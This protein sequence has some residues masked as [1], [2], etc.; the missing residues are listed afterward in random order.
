MRRSAGALLMVLCGCLARNPAFDAASDAGATPVTTTGSGVAPTSSET[1]ATSGTT[2]DAT[3]FDPVATGEPSTGE[4]TTSTTTTATSATTDAEE[5][6]PDGCLATE[7]VQL[8]AV[9]LDTAV[10]PPSMPVPCPWN[11]GQVDPEHDCGEFNFGLA[12]SH[13]LVHGN[14][15]KNAALLRFPLAMITGSLESSGHALGDL[16]GFRLVV[17]FEEYVAA[18]QQTYVFRVDLLH[19]KDVDF[20][21]GDKVSGVAGFGDSSFAC[22]RNEGGQCVPWNAPGGPLAASAKMGVMRL[23]PDGVDLDET[24]DAYRIQVRSELLPS[25]ELV[26]RAA[27]DIDPA[28]AISLETK[29][30]V[31]DTPMAGLRIKLTDAPNWPQPR[32]NAVV[33]TMWR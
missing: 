15:G 10:V 33:C 8:D 18:P 1:G 14:K 19:A 4:A 29:R 12:H 25:D 3:T 6:L 9:A 22:K 17:V 13:P 23:E 32:L 26:A 28:L 27:M 30:A 5:P 21:V 7:E 16:V 31:F 24:E 20:H 11:E 2:T